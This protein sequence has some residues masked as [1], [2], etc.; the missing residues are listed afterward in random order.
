MSSKI[1]SKNARS[2]NGY[3]I[4]STIPA[5]SQI[6]VFTSG[7]Y[8]PTTISSSNL[9]NANLTADAAVR[10]Y[11]LAGSAVTDYLEFLSPTG[12]LLQL[13]GNDSIDFG[14]TSNGIKANFYLKTG[15]DTFNIYGSNDTI[16]H[17]FYGNYNA[18][19]NA[20]YWQ[21]RANGAD[22]LH[23]YN[24]DDG[25]YLEMIGDNTNI[26]SMRGRTVNHGMTIETVAGYAGLYSFT[27]KGYKT[28]NTPSMFLRGNDSGGFYAFG[29]ASTETSYRMEIYGSTLVKGGG[30]TSATT[31]ALFQNS[32]SVNTLS[33][34]D[35]GV[36][37]LGVN[38]ATGIRFD[39]YGRTSFA[40][41]QYLAAATSSAFLIYDSLNRQIFEI[42]SGGRVYAS[43]PSGGT[44]ILNA[45]STI[46]F[47]AV[48]VGDNFAYTSKNSLGNYTMYLRNQGNVGTF[49]LMNS[50]GTTQTYLAGGNGS[51]LINSLSI[52]AT[53]STGLFGVKGTG[54]T[55]A[56][57]TAL[58]QNSSSAA[59][60]TIKDDLSVT[61]GSVIEL[62]HASDTTISRVSSGKIAVEGVNVVTTSSTD[63][64]T[65][66]TLTSP[67]LYDAYT[68]FNI[69]L[70]VVNNSVDLTANRTLLIDVNDASR[71]LILRGNLLLSG[72]FT[73]SGSFSTN[74]TATA[75]TTLTLPTTGTLSTLAG[76]ET[77]T[78]KTLTAPI[79]TAPVTIKH[80][81]GPTLFSFQNDLNGNVEIGR[82]DNVASTPYLDFHSGAVSVDYDTRILSSGGNGTS[83]NGTLMISAATLTTTGAISATASISTSSTIEL[84]HASDT[85]I[86][87]VSAGV[88]SIEG[89]N[90]VTRT[91]TDTLTNKR[92]TPRVGTTTSSA[93]PTI[94][95]DIVDYYELTAQAVDITSFTT[96]L[97]GTPTKG[98]KLWIAITGT[99]ARAI[100]WGASFEA[101][102]I[103]LPTTTVSTNRLDVGFIWNDVTNKWRCVGS[104]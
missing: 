99:A 33:L 6:L 11:T 79:L 7:K 62:G 31:T 12:R 76:N 52:G 70:D 37:Q 3:E 8:V 85:T 63:T 65:N 89:V 87:R 72:A 27:I 94:N 59:C 80:P 91:S 97:S 24:Y 34:R 13:K 18:T 60:L 103:A 2:L 57:T 20:H 35:D 98:Q 101:S 40:M 78:N 44:A 77:L 53:S 19:T 74:L 39:P 64:L 50:A 66:K 26:F 93:T 68:G 30:A 90:I 4:V 23:I 22:T 47:E 49:E 1:T 104:V 41:L 45:N 9:G 32:S 96:N 82:Q 71:Q 54:S 55:S 84:G 67:K 29:G 102:T 5:E 36:V 48:A 42:N 16:A 17:L 10:S 95:T 56:T 14:S 51:Y 25:Q 88:V 61:F 46:N 86:A 38:G 28:D 69:I 43:V 21:R 92:V 100:T 58:F 83:G 73:T 15:S 81:T 75:N